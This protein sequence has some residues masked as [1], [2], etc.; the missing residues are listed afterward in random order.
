MTPTFFSARAGVVLFRM[1]PVPDWTIEKCRSAI[2]RE[3]LSHPIQSQAFGVWVDALD[4]LADAFRA[5]MDQRAD[6]F[7]P[8]PPRAA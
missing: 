2:V 3:G 8:Q 7:T 4:Q 1:R 5:A 6:T